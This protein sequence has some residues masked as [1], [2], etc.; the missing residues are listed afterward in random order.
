MKIQQTERG[1]SL[2]ERTCQR[3]EQ[4]QHPENERQLSRLQRAELAPGDFRKQ[5]SSPF[6]VRVVRSGSCVRP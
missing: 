2:I 4:I 3:N 6:S 1:D 5:A